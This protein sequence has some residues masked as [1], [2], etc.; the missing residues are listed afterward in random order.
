MQL[1]LHRAFSRQVVETNSQ[2]YQNAIKI[3]WKT[4]LVQG[5]QNCQI[6]TCS[7]LASAHS[8]PSKEYTGKQTTP[9]LHRQDSGSM[10]QT[11]DKS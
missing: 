9:F 3:I 4:Y 5:H 10:T 6:V 7:L 8:V 2:T 11:Q 1:L